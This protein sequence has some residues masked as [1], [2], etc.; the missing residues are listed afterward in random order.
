MDYKPISIRLTLGTD[1]KLAEYLGKFPDVDGGR[2]GVAKRL[3]HRALGMPEPP[4]SIVVSQE[5]LD[6]RLQRA[7]ELGAMKALQRVGVLKNG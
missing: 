6:Q 1:D 3:M 7:A 2:A 4:F 5:E